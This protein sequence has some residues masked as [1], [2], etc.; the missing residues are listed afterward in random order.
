MLSL[1]LT[2]KILLF[3]H[4]TRVKHNRALVFL[5]SL[6]VILFCY[7]LIYLRNSRKKYSLG[8]LFY[9]AVSL[10]IFVD[11]VYYSYFNALPSIRMVKQIG[12]VPAVGDSVKTLLSFRNLLFC[13]TYPWPSFT[14]EEKGV[15]EDLIDI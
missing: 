1:L 15:L 2:L 14:Q 5:I 3:M 11:V 10:I 9:A 6:L 7:S 13:W 8:F 12:Q 4:I